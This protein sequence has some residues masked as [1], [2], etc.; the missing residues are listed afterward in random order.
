M[1]LLRASL[2]LLALLAPQKQARQYERIDMA[3]SPIWIS[4]DGDWDNTAS[5]STGV[6]PV[7]TDT[8]VFDGVSSVV[9]V[10]SNL[11][12]TGV[13]LARI[14]ISPEY[15]GDIGSTGSPLQIDATVVLHRGTGT[16]YLKGDGGGIGVQVDST[17]LVDAL[18]L[19]GTSTLL[20]L[21]VK[22]GHATVD[23]T[24]TNLGGVRVIG[25]KAIV[26]IEANGAEK[27][28]SIIQQAGFCENNRPLSDAAAIAIVNGGVF[29][30]ENGAVTQLHVQG[31]TC[32][33][34]AVETLTLGLVGRGL[35]DFTRSGNVKTVSALVILPGAEVFTTSQTTVA[36]TTDFRKEIP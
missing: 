6:L 15:T 24:V 9:S 25:D 12:Q 11:N 23:N 35:L 10:T 20:T 28:T 31:G 34:N 18:V 19:S 26:I 30:H 21:D 36:A 27:I 22:K 32:E 4:S 14:E 8:A 16:L 13:D 5:W 7:S 29:V 33:W 17:N 3:A 1:Q 2:I